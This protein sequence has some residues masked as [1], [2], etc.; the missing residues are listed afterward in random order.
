ML[1]LVV[2]PNIFL[3]MPIEIIITSPYFKIID[4]FCMCSHFQTRVLIG[5]L[6]YLIV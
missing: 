1:E 6:D 5:L 2:L 4:F 3:Q